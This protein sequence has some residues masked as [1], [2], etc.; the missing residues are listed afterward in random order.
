MIVQSGIQ[1]DVF[2]V[3][4][5]F[6]L[7]REGCW[8]RDL[9][10][11]SCLLDRFA[12]LGKPVM[13]SALQVPSMPPEMMPGVGASPGIWRRPWSDLLQAK[14]L[15][16]VTDIALSKPFVEAVCWQDLVDMP[17]NMLAGAQSVPFG[18]LTTPELTPKPALR[19]GSALRRAV[20][21]FRQAPVAAAGG[22]AATE[23]SAEERPGAL[24]T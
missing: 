22:A 18:G 2:G 5:K 6:G 21:N 8:Q 15:E 13:I 14:W 9:F 24:G 20:M 16:A 10:Q 12:A 4:L 11:V 3:Q 23:A 1:F 19:T 7:P 17:A